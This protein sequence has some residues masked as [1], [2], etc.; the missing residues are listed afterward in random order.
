[1]LAHQ[2][3]RFWNE[4][5]DYHLLDMPVALMSRRD[6][7]QRLDPVGSVLPDP[8]QDA[9]REWDRQLSGKRQSRQAT[10]GS[11]VGGAAVGR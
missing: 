10:L 9:G 8:D 2:G 5:L 11:L 1:M 4:V 3:A 6:R 7:L